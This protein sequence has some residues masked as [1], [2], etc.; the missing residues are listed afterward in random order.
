[1]PRRQDG[2]FEV[3]LGNKQLLSI[4]FIVVILFGVFFTMGYIFGRNS[5]GPGA[6]AATTARQEA[7]EP[8][9]RETAWS[10]VEEA[11]TE[12]AEVRTTEPPPAAPPARAPAAEPT[13]PEAP[14]PGQTFLQVAAVKRPEAELLAEVLREQ[15]FRS[16]VAPHPTEPIYRVLVGPLPDA[17]VV[18]R[19]RAGL[20]SAGFKPIVRRY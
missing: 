9:S 3:M 11:Q 19:T 16:L 18:A 8:A 12:A 6:S 1:M 13:T 20:E 4:F 15:G 2:E 17:D 5:A 10:V 7:A 14:A